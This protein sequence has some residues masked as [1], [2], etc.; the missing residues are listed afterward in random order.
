LIALPALLLDLHNYI[1]KPPALPGGSKSLTAPYFE[2]LR[3]ADKSAAT[4]LSGSNL[5]SLGFTGGT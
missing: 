5:S 2:T 4:A 1:G 3:N